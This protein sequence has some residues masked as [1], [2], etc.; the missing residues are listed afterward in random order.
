MFQ[1]SEVT[2]GTKVRVHIPQYKPVRDETG[3][4]TGERFTHSLRARGVVAET[5]P[6]CPTCGY[7]EWNERTSHQDCE[8][9]LT[10]IYRVEIQ[11]GNQCNEE[12]DDN[13]E[14]WLFRKDLTPF[15]PRTPTPPQTVEKRRHNRKRWKEI[16]DEKIAE[17]RE[18]GIR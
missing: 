12:R 5:L 15:T 3:R 18:P 10:K 1:A 9:P 4:K 14:L 6:Y 8:G 7:L 13:G 2:L 17:G 11:N 16:R